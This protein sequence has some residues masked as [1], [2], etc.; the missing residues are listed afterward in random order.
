MFQNIIEAVRMFFLFL[1]ILLI[2]RIILS[3]L[4]LFSMDL[5]NSK[6]AYLIFNLTESLLSPIRRVLMKSP[7]GGPGMMIDF[8]VLILFFL[9]QIVESIV[10]SLLH[11][12]M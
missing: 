5:R 1:R 2:A 7:L 11:G 10:I 6:I 8:S 3:W 4:S 9:I 12:F